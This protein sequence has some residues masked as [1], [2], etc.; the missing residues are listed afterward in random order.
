MSSFATGNNKTLK[1]ALKNKS[2]YTRKRV[3]PSTKNHIYIR[4]KALVRESSAK[5]VQG[6]TIPATFTVKPHCPIMKNA[7]FKNIIE[8]FKVIDEEFIRETLKKEC[9]DGVS[10]LQG[11]EWV[12]S[13]LE[14]KIEYLDQNRELQVGIG[15][16][17][18]AYVHKSNI[19]KILDLVKNIVKSETVQIEKEAAEKV[20]SANK[21]R[22]HQHVS[23]PL[24]F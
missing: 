1:S 23:S 14:N 15:E 11:A 19:Q 5:D 9:M 12:K 21:R 7:F 20:Q 3:T 13:Y 4:P 18:L 24:V 10:V 8:N 16:Y 17:R 22:K 2:R 6:N